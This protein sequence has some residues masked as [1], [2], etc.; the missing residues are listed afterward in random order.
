MI[1]R[2]WATRIGKSPYVDLYVHFLALVSP[3][4]PARLIA[5]MKDIMTDDG[6]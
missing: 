4:P 2:A 3:D 1:Q 5:R 6:K